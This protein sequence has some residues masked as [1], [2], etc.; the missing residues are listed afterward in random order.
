M[1]AA[2]SASGSAMRA[3]AASRVRCVLMD[4]FLDFGSPG[5]P[6]QRID[7]LS[8]V[9]DL[10]VKPGSR[11]RSSL[12]HRSDRLSAL[13]TVAGSDMH[14]VQ[15]ARDGQIAAAVVEDDHLTI[16]TEPTGE[17]HAAGRDCRHRRAGRS[18]DLDAG[19]QRLGLELPVDLPPETRTHPAR[20]RARRPATD[21]P[22]APRCR[23]RAGHAAKCVLE[24]RGRAAQFSGSLLFA[25]GPRAQ[26]R[27]EIAPLDQSFARLLFAP[28][29]LAARLRDFGEERLAALAA[30]LELR[31]GTRMAGGHLAG[32]PADLRQAR[33]P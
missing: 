5:E 22:R 24:T 32:P 31:A 11:R 18:G 30:R 25:R 2:R 20:E 23:G 1:I 10:K 15:V 29:R 8:V 6:E 13:D 14:F 33:L 16:T 4:A 28:A 7:G 3:A 17:E 12:A 9:T 27:D 19:P 21:Q 26:S